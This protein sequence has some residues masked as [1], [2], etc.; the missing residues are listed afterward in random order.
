[1]PRVSAPFLAG[2]IGFAIA[3]SALAEPVDLTID[4]DG[5]TLAGTLELPETAA[6]VAALIL[7][8]SGPT[9]R[10][11]NSALG[12]SSD[13]YRLLAEALAEAG[14]ATARIDKRGVG[15]S[16]GDGN[17]VSLELYRVDTAAWIDELRAQTDATCVW[18]IGHSEGAII[19]LF[20]ADLPNLCGLIL[21]TPP[22]RPLGDLM[23]DQMALNPALATFLPA[24][25]AAIAAVV[26]GQAPDLSALPPPLA[27]LFDGPASAYL[28]ELLRTSPA[29]LLAAT[30]LPTLIV[31]GDADIQVPPSEAAALSDARATAQF[32]VLSGLTHLLKTATPLAD[33]A[34]PEAYVSESLATYSAPDMPLHAALV[35]A[36]LD[37]M[38]HAE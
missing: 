29:T 6:P 20:S 26:A 7:P 8:G 12:I 34:T 21:L 14:I 33:A 18:L 31:H 11:G 27:A 19:A 24:I 37:F 16:G 28:A 5:V 30:D 38:G 4:R 32:L 2:L 9:D 23:L 10:N 3:T 22:G 25:E 1:M 13:S 36:L 35:P 17:A 15:G